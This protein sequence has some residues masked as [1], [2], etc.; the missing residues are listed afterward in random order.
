M[1]A[2]DDP[3]AGQQLESFGGVAAAHD[4]QA[5]GTRA[6]ALGHPGGEFVA[7]IAAVGP[8]ELEVSY[9]IISETCG[10]NA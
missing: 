2:F 3:A 6:E 5:Q 10:K 9:R 8:E 1:G 7:R 4:L